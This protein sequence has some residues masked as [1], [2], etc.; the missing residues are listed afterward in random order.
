MRAGLCA[1]IGFVCAHNS[2]HR[3]TEELMLFVG[4]WLPRHLGG[5][6]A[7]KADS[8]RPFVKG[9]KTSQT[10]VPK[11]GIKTISLSII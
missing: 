1:R 5:V 3:Y 7:S 8:S 9:P 6:E 11:V 10:R 2:A 4:K